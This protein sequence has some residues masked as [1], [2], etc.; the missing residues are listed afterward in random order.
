L[1]G[2]GTAADGG[3]GLA[4]AGGES[5]PAGQLFRTGE[6]V[7]VTNL[8]GEDRSEG[9]SD[10]AD[11]LDDP[12]PAMTAKPLS[13]HHPKHLDLTVIGIDQLQ[14]GQ[15][16]LAINQIQRRGAQPRHPSHS[17]HIRAR[18]EQTLLG[19]HPVHLSLQP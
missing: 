7:N 19:Q 12:I 8:G 3:I 2:D 6:P 5:S 13:N 9:R 1:F 11:L 17:E 15:H 4:M 18:R 10:P 16:P 14:Q